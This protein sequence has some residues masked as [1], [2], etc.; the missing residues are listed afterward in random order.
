M[1]KNKFKYVWIGIVVLYLVTHLFNLTSLPVFADEA[2]YIR[3]SQLILDDWQRYLFFPLNDGKTPLFVWTMVPFIRIIKDPLLAGRLVSVLVGLAQVWLMMKLTYSLTK[4]RIASVVVGL[5]TTLLPFWFFHHRMALMDAMMT[6]WLTLTLWASVKVSGKAK[7]KINWQI[8]LAVSL[9]AALWTKLPAIL[10]VPVL[11]FAPFLV[12]SKLKLNI[13][14]LK[15]YFINLAL[16]IFG[17]LVIFLSLKLHPAFSQ[18]FGRGGDFL[19]GM[20]ELLTGS[21]WQAMKQ[22]PKYGFAIWLYLTPM[23]VLLPI[24]G[25][26]TSRNKTHFWLLVMALVFA[27]PIMI[28]GKVVYTR[29]LFPLAVPLTISA[30]IGLTDFI[31]RVLRHKELCQRALWSLVAVLVLSNILGPV[32]QQLYYSWFSPDSLIFTESDRVQYLT[33]W[34]SGHGIKETTDLILQTAK[35]QKVAVATEGYFGTLPDGILMYLHNQDV[36]NIKVD[37][38]GQPVREISDEFWQQATSY[39]QV[40]LVVNSH[41]NYLKLDKDSLIQE[42][43]RPY[44]GPCLQVWR[45]R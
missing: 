15:P 44:S 38:V 8:I 33:E 10:F 4:E 2:I 18:L 25:L 26:K 20:D 3:W 32:T 14:Q 41:R 34:S 19:Y 35:T 30:A 12:N 37:G 24:A 9:G 13:S 31:K 7:N 27:L 36:N 29:Y 42:Y 17:G 16:P 45:L 43:C 22:W 40:W 39:D 21:W 6:M 5:L 23:I 11:F 1:L 28:M